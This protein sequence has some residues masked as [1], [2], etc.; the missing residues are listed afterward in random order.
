MGNVGVRNTNPFMDEMPFAEAEETPKGRT[1]VEEEV[2]TIGVTRSSEF[3]VQNA[4]A[5]HLHD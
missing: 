1:V 5:H 4:G 3:A 2:E